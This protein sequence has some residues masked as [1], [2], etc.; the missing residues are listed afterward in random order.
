M[1]Q[2]LKNLCELVG[3]SGFEQDVQRFIKNEIENKVDELEV[4]A[5]GNLIATIKATDPQLP[6]ILLAAHADEIGFIVKKIEPN[7]TLRF[8]QLGGFDNR[9][10]L[11]Q[12]V[13]IK[14]ADGYIEGVIGT[15]AVHYVKWDDPKRI[16]SHRDL[17][18]DVGASSAQEILEMG[19]KVGQ[20]ISYGSGLKLVGDKK[21]NRV[22]GKALDD[23]SGCAVLIELINNLQSKKDSKHGEIYCVFT[24]QEEVGLRGASVLSPNLKPDFALAI[25]TTPTSDTYDVLMTGTRKLGSGPCIKIADKSLISH[26]LVTGL[27]EKVAVEQNIPHQQEIFMG[28]GTDAGAI[29]MTSTGVSS[30]VISIPSRY[31]HTP[32]EIVDLDDLNNTVRLVE[33]F[34]FSSKSLVGKNFLD[35]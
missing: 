29:H 31:T 25:D 9:V 1:Y 13:T 14:G 4:D 8:E 23:R 33:A 24:V 11:A 7:G 22:V 32:I 17:Y 3:P 6:S 28:I 15:L 35:T 30:G 27:L 2:L 21:R 26:P 16:T 18:I 34:I 20:P 10:L 19:I 12:P 5:L